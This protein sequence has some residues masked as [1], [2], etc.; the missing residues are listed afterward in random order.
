MH[1]SAQFLSIP[2][3]A[4]DPASGY[5]YRHRCPEK[6]DRAR[7]ENR[8][9]SSCPT[10]RCVKGSSREASPST[11]PLGRR[12]TGNRSLGSTRARFLG[13]LLCSASEGPDPGPSSRPGDFARAPLTRGGGPPPDHDVRPPL[14]HSAIHRP[15]TPHPPCWAACPDIR[16]A[17]RNCERIRKPLLTTLPGTSIVTGVP[18]SRTER[19]LKTSVPVAA[20]PGFR[21]TVR[22]RGRPRVPG[23][24]WV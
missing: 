18:R 8:C 19:D 22:S 4:I 21:E 10:G 6:S 20:P 14:G 24:G 5:L 17:W 11:A 7:L 13:T 3:S 23:S 16:P 12:E 9:T 2:E 15:S 1:R